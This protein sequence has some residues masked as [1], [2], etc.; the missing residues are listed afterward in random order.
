MNYKLRRKRLIE[1]LKKENI[2]SF[3][4]LNQHHL[5]YLCSFKGEGA[6]FVTKGKTLIL[7]DSRYTEHAKADLRDDENLEVMEVNKSSIFNLPEIFSQFS[8]KSVALEAKHI[9]YDFFSDLQ[10]KCKNIELYPVK[11]WVEEL[12][13]V[14]ENEE[15]ENIRNACKIVDK[16]LDSLIKDI[17]WGVSEKDFV[18]E[19][20]YKLK[21]EGSGELPFPPIVA[22]GV[23]ASFPHA[24]PTNEKIK[25]GEFLVIDCG[26]SYKGY[27]CDLTRTIG[28]NIIDEGKKKIYNLVFDAQKAAIDSIKPGIKASDLYAV[29]YEVFSK[30]G[31]SK[32][33]THGL[34]HGVGL[35]VHEAPS[36]FPKESVELKEGMVFTIEPGIYVLNKYGVRIEDL[37]L[38]TS[39]G[40]E[41]LTTSPKVYYGN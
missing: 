39:K 30:Q 27:V 2:D 1:K 6:V 24:I 33:F 38:V 18:V 8:I 36:L 40:C 29:A 31:V 15:I 37:V 14:K 28:K 10:N 23:R 35:Q 3:F 25:E 17:K 5:H 16:V 32:L 9:T 11:D 20:E 4:T 19:L 34:G 21:K 12:R 41:V 13:I 7:V 22:G 26:A